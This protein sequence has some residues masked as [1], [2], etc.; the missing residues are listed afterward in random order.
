MGSDPRRA[1]VVVAVADADPTDD[2]VE[3][4]AAEAA[5]R[6]APLVVVHVERTATM[7]STVGPVPDGGRASELCGR[8]TPRRAR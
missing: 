3:W 6:S 1:P 8:G 4:A 2:A 5:A 7:W